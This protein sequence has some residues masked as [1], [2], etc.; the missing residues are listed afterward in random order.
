MVD[1]TDK[2]IN[3]H[4]EPTEAA[5]RAYTI[6]LENIDNFTA[7]QLLSL[8]QKIKEKE[9]KTLP[10]QEYSTNTS[11]YCLQSIP[12][13]NQTQLLNIARESMPKLSPEN[14]S[15]LIKEKPLEF[16]LDHLNKSY[17]VQFSSPDKGG[18]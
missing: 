5:Q 17:G 10:T 12:I 11:T 1:N 3:R 13:W 9:Q 7:A 15:I 2:T 18:N 4:L 16:W 14:Y 8:E 6:T